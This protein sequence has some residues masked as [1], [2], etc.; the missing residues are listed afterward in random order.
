MKCPICKGKKWI[1]INSGEP[2]KVYSDNK[3]I[4]NAKGFIECLYCKRTGKINIFKCAF[5]YIKVLLKTI[6]IILKEE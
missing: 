6:M 5:Y 3:E 2:V 1:L 4:M